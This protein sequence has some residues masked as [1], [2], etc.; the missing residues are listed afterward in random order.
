MAFGHSSLRWFEACS[1]KPAPR[2][3]NALVAH[4]VY[5]IGTFEMTKF[6]QIPSEISVI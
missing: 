5:S 4:Y 6:I 3:K 1:C 2:V